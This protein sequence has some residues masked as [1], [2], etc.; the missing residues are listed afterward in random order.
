MHFA[1]GVG[2]FTMSIDRNVMVPPEAH[3]I[4]KAVKAYHRSHQNAWPKGYQQLNLPREMED[5]RASLDRAKIK[6]GCFNE[7]ARSRKRER[8]DSDEDEETRVGVTPL[9]ASPMV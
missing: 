7:I 3:L 4:L 1:T 6:I 5:F 9:D 8:E 2:Y